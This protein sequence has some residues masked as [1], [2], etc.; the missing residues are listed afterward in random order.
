[1]SW[2]VSIYFNG[3]DDNDIFMV[4][5]D[6]E[7]YQLQKNFN[8]GTN[9]FVIKTLGGSCVFFEFSPNMQ[10]HATKQHAYHITEQLPE[11]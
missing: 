6:E 1:M 8:N 7:F 4:I 9:R 2:S 10:I 5:D 3:C 11:C